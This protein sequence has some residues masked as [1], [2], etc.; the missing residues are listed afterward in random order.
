MKTITFYS[1]KGGVGRTLT[2]A[3]VAK[4]LARFG[5]KVVVVDFDLEAPGLHYKFDLRNTPEQP[6]RGILDLLYTFVTQGIP[7]NTLDGFVYDVG[8]KESQG[9][10]HLIPAGDVPSVAY[11]KK[12]AAINWH[13]LFYGGINPPGIPLFEELRRLIEQQL[14][15]DFLLIDA[16]TGITEIGGVATTVL[17]DVVVCLLINNLENLEGTRAVLQAIQRAPRPEDRPNPVEIL[18][19]LTRIPKEIDPETKKNIVEEVRHILNEEAVEL[20]D[21]LALSEIYILH[22][23]PALQIREVITL[24]TETKPEKSTLLQ[25]YLYFFGRLIPKEMLRPHVHGLLKEAQE[26]VWFD[27]D[28][29]QENLEILANFSGYPPVY[30]ALLQLYELRQSKN[31]LLLQTT[32]N[33]YNIIRDPSDPLLQT[34]IKKNYSAN[35]KWGK[36]IFSEETAREIWLADKEKD[37]NLAR[38]IAKNLFF[39]DKDRDCIEFSEKVIALLGQDLEIILIMIKTLLKA[40]RTD[41]AIGLIEKYNDNYY[42][43]KEFQKLWAE[44]IIISNDWKRALELT[45]NPAF[46]IQ[47]LRD[48]APLLAMRLFVLNDQV[49]K[50]TIDLLEGAFNAAMKGNQNIHLLQE[51]ERAFTIAGKSDYFEKLVREAKDP[52]KRLNTTINNIIEY[53]FGKLFDNCNNKY[54]QK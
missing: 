3:N 5:Q 41:E 8:S 17:S 15:P 16:R 43:N 22:S 9:S 33:Y 26:L 12:L 10:I 21:T 48:D 51:I 53:Y 24:D 14:Q 42:N 45:N 52:S 37:I 46:N 36:S 23:D 39:N 35:N 34:I 13:D 29:A 50:L 20:A 54:W 30:Q 40:D 47:Q 25:D 6:L 31:D 4:Y 44:I 7:P 1:Y 28:K 27:A 2:M 49:E 32:I 11:W 38:E 18:P 19:L